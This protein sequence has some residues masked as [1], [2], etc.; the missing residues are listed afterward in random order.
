MNETKHGAA[1]SAAGEFSPD[2]VAASM[3]RGDGGF[4][5]DQQSYFEHPVLRKS[6]W[7]WEIVWYFYVGGMMSGS[8]A[9]SAIT[10]TIGARDGEDR[11]MIRNARYVALIGSALSG[12]LLVKDL[13]RPERFLKMLRIF[14]LKSPMSVGVYAL[15]AFSAFAGMAAAEQLHRDGKLPINLAGFLPR[16]VRNALFAASAG[17]MVA[18]TG[19][20]ISATAIPVWNTGRRHIPAI[21]V[22]SGATTTC[23]LNTMLLVLTGGPANSI[24]KLEKFEFLVS[25]AEA[26]LLLDFEQRSGKIGQAFFGGATGK[27]LKTW[28]LLCGIAIP[29]L[30]HLPTLFASPNKPAKHNSLKS[31]LAAGLTLAGGYMLRETIMEAGRASADDPSAYLRPPE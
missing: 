25:L 30:V 15:S 20:L 14:K 31:L 26:A 12:A 23:A 11:V 27:R 9:L 22:C 28:T 21:F 24:R 3:A 13:G 19:V 4:G 8:A 2:A 5:R 18:Y 10:D 17:V 7:G 29:A 16:I 1:Y 6:H